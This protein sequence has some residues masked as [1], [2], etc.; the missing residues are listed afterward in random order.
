MN[1][2]EYT[3]QISVTKDSK[4]AEAR[5]YVYCRHIETRLMLD[6]VP[7]AHVLKK[8]ISMLSW[9]DRVARVKF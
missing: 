6:L 2:G 1:K 7:L 5:F 3:T 8:I 9:K 4:E